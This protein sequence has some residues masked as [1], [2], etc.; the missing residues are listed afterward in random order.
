MMDDA[1]TILGFKVK[2]ERAGR[3]FVMT[4]EKLPGCIGQVEDSDRIIPE[5]ERLIKAYLREI[6]GRKPDMKKTARP[7]AESPKAALRKK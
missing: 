3:H 7:P 2:I 1:I 5:M 6:A 4:S